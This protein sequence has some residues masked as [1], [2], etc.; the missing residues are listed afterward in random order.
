MSFADL[1]KNRAATIGAL[2]TAATK[3]KEGG[4][5]YEDDRFWSPTVDKA[6]NGF[7]IIR[8]LPA[9]TG[10]EL[11]W[12]RYWDHGFKGPTGKWYIENSLTTIGQD[13]PVSELNTRLWNSGN[14]KDKETVRIR[15][16]RLHYVAN[17]YIVSD[18]ANPKNDGTVRLYKFGK[19]IFDKCLDLMQPAFPD[20]KPVNPFDFWEGADF[21]IK[22]RN[23]E[24][25]RN[26]DKSEFADPAPLFGGDDAKLKVVYEKLVALKEFV[27]PK[28]YK[29]YAELKKKLVDVLG[30]EA[31]TPGEA[32]RVAAT[33]S[34]P[35]QTRKSAEATELRYAPA[36][37]TSETSDEGQDDE[38]APT[39]APVAPTKVGGETT[40]ETL[41]YFAQLA[42]QE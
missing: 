22:I 13:D 27:D 28:N 3:I 34:A 15:K 23:V 35:E 41:R 4:K 36:P 1:K 21:R 11:P 17:V 42:A 40:T 26:Y 8:F 9:A 2:T 7:A 16:R 33:P 39:P 31:L 25:Y 14:E 32:T 10:E 38:P 20:E 18:P 30:A 12:V 19:K 37:G 5:S 24:G 29:T 6:G